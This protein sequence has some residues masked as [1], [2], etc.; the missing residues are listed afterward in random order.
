VSESKE[1]IGTRPRERGGS[2]SSRVSLPPSQKWGRTNA[3][4]KRERERKKEVRDRE[5]ER[6]YAGFNGWPN[7][8]E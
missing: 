1:S 8:G 5:R 3:V 2:N 7:L 6:E 4:E